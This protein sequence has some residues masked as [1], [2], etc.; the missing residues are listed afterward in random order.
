MTAPLTTRERQVLQAA[1]HGYGQRRTARTL[2]LG[3]GTVRRHLQRA[4]RLL[5]AR[6]LT[7]AIAAARAAGLITTSS[8][9]Q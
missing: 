8:E 6:N 9:E 2:H 3:R 5:G 7:T 4:Q 1:A